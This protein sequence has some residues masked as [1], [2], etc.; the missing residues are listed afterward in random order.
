MP[1]AFGLIAILGSHFL[2]IVLFVLL[3]A[4]ISLRAPL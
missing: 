3:L 1:K 4:I 2:N